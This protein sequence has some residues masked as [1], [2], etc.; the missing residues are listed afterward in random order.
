M[1]Q[2][3]VIR[4]FMVALGFQTDNAGLAKMQEGLK[5]VEF[6]AASLNKALGALAIGAVLAVRQTAGELDKLYFSSQRIGASAGNINA[7]GNAVS[8][9]GGN[10]EAALGTLENLAEKMRNSPG[11]SGQLNSLGVQT[12]EANGEI[13]DRVEVMKDLSVVLGKMPDYQANAYANSLGIDQHTLLA[14]KDGKFISNMEKYQQLQKDM[15]MNDELTKSGNDFMSEYRDLTMVTKT[16]FQVIV[17]Q[18]GKALIPIL[19]GLN[20]MIQAGI[21]AFGQLNPQIKEGL[22][23]GLRFILLAG[24]FKV[25]LGVFGMISK[26]I[27]LVLGLT[28]GLKLLRLAFLASPIG[29][30]LALASALALLYGDYKTW[31]EGGKSLF[32][33]SKWTNGIDKIISKIKYFLDIL[34]KVKDKVVNFIQKVLTDPMGAIKEVGEAAAAGVV[35]LAK[36][37]GKA[38]DAIVNSEPVKQVTKW[39]D[40]FIGVDKL[41]PNST[42]QNVNP[43]ADTPKQVQPKAILPAHQYIPLPVQTKPPKPDQMSNEQKSAM[44]QAANGLGVIAKMAQSGVNAVVPQTSSHLGSVSAKYEGKIGSANKDVDQNGNPAGWAYGKYQFNSAKGGLSRFM[45]DNPQIANQFVGLKPETKAFADKW[46]EIAKSDPKGFEAAQD[47]SAANIWYAPAKNAYAKAGFNMNNRGVQEAV[48]SSSIQH[49]GVVRKLL[50][51]IQKQ[52]GRNISELTAEEQ[53][54]AIYKGRTTYHQRGKKRYD[55]ELKDALKLSGTSFVPNGT[56]NATLKKVNAH[57]SIRENPHTEQI[58]RSSMLA[59]SIT[60]HQSFKTDMTINGAREPQ[61]SASAVKRSQ[62]NSMAIMMRNAQGLIV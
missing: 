48:F 55:A 4:D 19:K 21:H 34:N 49:G 38:K 7:F 35:E 37:A 47:K 12:K 40:D 33:W 59:N 46:K 1:S 14:M 10:A 31:K 56:A 26:V 32:D 25:V 8:Q 11:Y 44:M 54:K 29:I 58:N 2:G 57:T 18:A 53:I 13:R 6:S 41:K 22:T 39:V 60:I 43:L 16:G 17:M 3:A 62:D 24:V 28:K 23:V 45:A 27:P 20:V 52:V 50:P 36:E 9:M 15:G 61:E 30:I 51:L 5:G 42:P